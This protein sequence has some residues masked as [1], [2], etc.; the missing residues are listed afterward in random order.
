MKIDRLLYKGYIPVC[1]SN[2]SNKTGHNGSF[3]VTNGVCEN[4]KVMPVS[5][6]CQ[7]LPCHHFIP[8]YV[9]GMKESCVLY[10]QRWTHNNTISFMVCK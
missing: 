7:G 2:T 5:S 8:F 1:T 6:Q 4:G 10:V 9:R 3:E